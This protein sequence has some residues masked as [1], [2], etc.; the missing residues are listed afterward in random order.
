MNVSSRSRASG[1]AGWPDAST[2]LAEQ[3]AFLALPVATLLG[4]A[5]VVQLFA[6][7]ESQLELGAPAVVE[8]DAQGNERHAF[9]L[10]RADQLVRFA[11]MQ[12]QFSRAARLMVQAIGLKVF[13]D[14]GVD[15]KD[16]AILLA[17]V[18]FGD[19]RLSLPQ[20]FH[21]R[22]A[23]RNPGLEGVLDE[24]REARLPVFGDNLS[25]GGW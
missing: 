24:V 16:L 17:G 7:R 1:K 18:G 12:E 4:F 11:L 13:G 2:P 14:I 19:V 6:A 25:N 5:L 10:D 15:E 23:K 20:R 21:L 3:A 22:A 8:V 9:A